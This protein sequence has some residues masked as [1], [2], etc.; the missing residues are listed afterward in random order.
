MTKLYNRPMNFFE[1]IYIGGWWC[2]QIFDE[3]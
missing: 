3:W 1:K 2:F